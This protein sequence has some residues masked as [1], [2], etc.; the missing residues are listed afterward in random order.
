MGT[1]KTRDSILMFFS[2]RGFELRLSL[3]NKKTNQKLETIIAVITN[4]LLRPN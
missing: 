4:Y 1:K 2:V 3:S